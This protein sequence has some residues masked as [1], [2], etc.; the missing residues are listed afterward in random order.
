MLPAGLG[1]VGQEEAIAMLIRTWS[2]SQLEGGDEVQDLYERLLRLVEP[3]LLKAAMQHAGG[4]CLAASR[5]LGLHRTTLR[6]KLDE[7]GIGGEE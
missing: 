4:Q 1:H 7:L 6:K 2:E 3:P 5:H